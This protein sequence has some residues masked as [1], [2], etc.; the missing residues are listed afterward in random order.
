MKNISVQLHVI[1]QWSRRLI[2]S[3]L[4][5]CSVSSV[6]AQTSLVKGAM[7]EE[8]ILVDKQPSDKMSYATLAKAFAKG[9]LD[10]SL[11][12]MFT[13][14]SN[15]KTACVKSFSEYLGRTKYRFGVNHDKVE[16][17]FSVNF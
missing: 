7:G 2:M 8:T 17:K 9:L 4:F 10:M 6:H 3:L 5:L 1:G 16:V 14:G 12:T 11:E 15:K 13:G